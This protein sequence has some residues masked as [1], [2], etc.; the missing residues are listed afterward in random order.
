MGIVS[1]RWSL[2]LDYQ[3]VKTGRKEATDSLK[4]QLDLGQRRLLTAE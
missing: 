1:S 2:Q 4:I 3:P